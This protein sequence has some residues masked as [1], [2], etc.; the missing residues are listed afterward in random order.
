MYRKKIIILGTGILVVVIV[1]IAIFFIGK[2]NISVKTKT[3]QNIA[4]ST[5]RE[6]SRDEKIKVHIDP[7]VSAEVVNDQNGLYIYRIKK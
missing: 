4:T 7:N 5:I 1:L 3:N 2:K 6:M